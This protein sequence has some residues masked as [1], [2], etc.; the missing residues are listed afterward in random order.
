MANRQLVTIFGTVQTVF[1]PDL[2]L[3]EVNEIITDEGHTEV[4]PADVE[5][6][7]NSVAPS[8]H[9]TFRSLEDGDEFEISVDAHLVAGL[10]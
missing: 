3:V 8:D 5:I 9:C 6:D 7:S 10:E 2:V 1:S 4:D